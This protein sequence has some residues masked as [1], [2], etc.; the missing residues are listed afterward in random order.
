[1]IHGSRVKVCNHAP[2]KIMSQARIIEVL[3]AG[4]SD[5]ESCFHCPLSIPIPRVYYVRKK[6]I[7]RC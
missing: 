2:R 3:E 6:K 1:M 7:L 5:V 4:N